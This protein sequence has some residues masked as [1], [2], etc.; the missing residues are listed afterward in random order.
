MT[1]SAP[2][3]DAVAGNI[4]SA[5]ESAFG[6]AKPAPKAAPPVAAAPEPE[7]EEIEAAPPPEDGE[8]LLEAEPT[9]EAPPVAE[10]EIEIEVDGRKE[11]VRGSDKIKELAQKGYHYSKGTEEVARAKE[12]I[13]AQVH[14]LELNQ[15]FH[16]AIV[17][18]L[19][20]L[21]ALDK[22]LEAYNK[23]DWS[24]AIDT[25]FVEAMKAQEQR[26]QLRE[27]RNQK[28]Q[29]LQGKKSQFDEGQAKAAQQLQAAEMG[30]LLAKL[31]SWRNSETRTAEDAA[32][33]TELA[34]YGF[35]DQEIGSIMDHRMI[36]VARDAMKYR[37]LQRSKT[38]AVKQVRAA[39]AV[40]KPGAAGAQAQVT[41]KEKFQKFQ[42]NF[43]A[44]GQKGQHRAQEASL[45]KLFSRTFK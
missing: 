11:I 35:R 39:P 30:Q 20:E 33:R 41:A 21:Q 36:L 1:E 26:A 19:A 34:N 2:S 31:P 29:E 18:D 28:L 23:I 17:G 32:I 22:Q 8:E 12:Q 16:G 4:E 6:G 10:P 42:A 7:V 15:K 13:A 40:S 43:K 44:Q 37:A 14:I 5:I 9:E 38:D 24:T 3:D 27:A 25:N 45:E